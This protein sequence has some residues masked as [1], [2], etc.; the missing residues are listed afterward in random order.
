MTK[1]EEAQKRAE[2]LS[3]KVAVLEKQIHEHPETVSEKF[4]DELKQVQKDVQDQ[5]S[6]LMKVLLGGV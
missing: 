2:E 1:L 6:I 4:T 5:I 3:V